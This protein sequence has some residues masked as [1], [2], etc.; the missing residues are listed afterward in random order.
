MGCLEDAEAFIENLISK[1]EQEPMP[2]RF[3][4]SVHNALASNVA[5]DQKALA[6]NSAPTVG[7][8]SFE[9]ALWHG[10]SQLA[11]GECDMAL[12]GAADEVNDYVLSITKR[13]NVWNGR[14]C[15]GE[16]AV[17]ASL[18]KAQPGTEVIAKIENVRLGRYRR[19]YNANQEADWVSS[20]VDLE[21][22]EVV[23]TGAGGTASLEPMYESF[24]AALSARTRNKLRFET[25]KDFCGEFHAASGFGFASAVEL[26]RSGVKGVL[27]YTL[28]VRGG[29]ALC[30]VRP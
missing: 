23:L 2:A 28:A 12:A 15:S 26:T 8:I 17:I 22:I 25:Y 7:E 1:D 29:K 24:I 9:C 11:I 19:P 10:M 14:T 6:M 27:I 13:W 30:I 5:I 4:N 20:S 3:P 16:G 18:V 21:S